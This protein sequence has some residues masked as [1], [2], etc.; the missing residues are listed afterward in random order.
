MALSREVEVQLKH[1]QEQERQ[2][3]IANGARV[4]LDIAARYLTPGTVFCWEGAEPP[5]AELL[6]ADRKGDAAANRQ[7]SREWV[8]NA[9]NRAR[10]AVLALV[11]VDALG[12]FVAPKDVLWSDLHPLFVAFAESDASLEEVTRAG[13]AVAEMRE[14]LGER[15]HQLGSYFSWLASELL[16]QVDPE[17]PGAQPGKKARS[18]RRVGGSKVEY[19]PKADTRLVE[20]WRAS[21]LKRAEFEK[22]RGLKERSVRKA[23]DRIKAR[24]KRAD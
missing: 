11:S 14:Q 1:L 17:R 21:G 10:G 15:R 5:P 9:W 23:Q 3:G 8:Q 7:R 19:D 4:A 24:A 20:D 2:H 13:T 22:E 6:T 16:P 18:G 12:R